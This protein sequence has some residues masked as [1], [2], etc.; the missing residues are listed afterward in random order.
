MENIK[1]IIEQ[2]STSIPED[3][4]YQ[5][6]ASSAYLFSLLYGGNP[7]EIIDKATVLLDNLNQEVKAKI[8]EVFPD[9][10]HLGVYLIGLIFGN[11]LVYSCQSSIKEVFD[12]LSQTKQG[13]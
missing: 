5:T 7:E 13:A 6:A 10:G 12:K 1:Q 11:A 2:L 3:A 8:L 9:A 4:L